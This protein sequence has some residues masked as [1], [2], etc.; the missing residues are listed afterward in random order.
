MICNVLISHECPVQVRTQQKL[1]FILLT[2]FEHTTSLLALQWVSQD[3]YHGISS[4][5]H[6]RD[7]PVLVDW[8]GLFLALARLR[9]FSP[10][11]LHILENH[12]AM[13]EIKR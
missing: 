10:H 1:A 9:D 13:S 3:K 8:L 4:Q 6:F 12:V 5:E 2:V 7:V 11:L